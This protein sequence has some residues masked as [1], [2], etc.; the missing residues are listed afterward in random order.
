LS[1]EDRKENDYRLEHGFRLLFQRLSCLTNPFYPRLLTFPETD[2]SSRLV[3]RNTR[4]PQ[5]SHVQAFGYLMTA[6]C[7]ADAPQSIDLEGF[8]PESRTHA[9]RSDR[10][11]CRVRKTKLENQA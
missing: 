5:A 4:M 1:D 7:A 3:L 10:M 9:T 2:F 8:P 11:W 6:R